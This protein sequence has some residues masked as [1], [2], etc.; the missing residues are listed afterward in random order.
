MKI[1]WNY[2][3]TYIAI[4]SLLCSLYFG[5]VNLNLQNKINKLHVD[6]S[7]VTAIQSQ[8]SKYY[9]IVKNISPVNIIYL[10]IKFNVLE[11]SMK[12]QKIIGIST[13]TKDILN[14]AE[15]IKIENELPPDNIASIFLDTVY[16]NLNEIIEILQFDITYY[17]AQD[18]KMYTYKPTY[19]I[20]KGT[21]YTSESALTKKLI[22]DLID[23]ID[24][25]SNMQKEADRMKSKS[26]NEGDTLFKIQR[27]QN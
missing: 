20:S 24:D 26:D 7:I 1:N 8:K 15:T 5:Y 6:A 23:V 10:K 17:R 9:L 13:K 21:I 3:E 16:G 19:F 4:A 22:P 25:I 2:A 12:H 27:P 11:Y 14:E 18:L